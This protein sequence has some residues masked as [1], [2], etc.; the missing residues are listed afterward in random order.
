[1][2]YKNYNENHDDRLIDIANELIDYKPKKVRRDK[3]F[4]FISRVS[5]IEMCVK[6]MNIQNSCKQLV[7]L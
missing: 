6:M 3:Y 2:I 4:N 1:M 5:I 7:L